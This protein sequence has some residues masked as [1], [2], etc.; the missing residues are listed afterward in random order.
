MSLGGT[1]SQLVKLEGQMSDLLKTVKIREEQENGEE[2]LW[3][4][5]TL[6]TQGKFETDGVGAIL[7][8]APQSTMEWEDKC[9][10]YVVTGGEERRHNEVSSAT[11]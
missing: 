6:I 2:K 1:S 10:T 5:F 8:K 4:I 7:G 11:L 9:S 3:Q